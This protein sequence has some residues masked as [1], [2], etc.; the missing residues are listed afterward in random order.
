M[1]N[2]NA[3]LIALSP[4]GIPSETLNNDVIE[5]RHAAEQAINRARAGDGP[6][7]A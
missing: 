2:V 6:T 3:S 7:L 1:K 4:Y 5:I